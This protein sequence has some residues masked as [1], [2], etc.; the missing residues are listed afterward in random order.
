[1]FYVIFILLIFSYLAFFYIFTPPPAAVTLF[2]YTCR[3]NTTYSGTNDWD[4]LHPSRNR[5][6]C[7]RWVADFETAGGSAKPLGHARDVRREL[8]SHQEM[9]HDHVNDKRWFDWRKAA[10]LLSAVVVILALVVP[11]AMRGVVD[12]RPSQVWS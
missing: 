5:D 6:E 9:L 7:E 12:M 1:M 2:P 3:A 4:A 8:R 10:L 11:S